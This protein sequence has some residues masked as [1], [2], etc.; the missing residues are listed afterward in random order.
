M[1]SDG[2]PILQRIHSDRIVQG[3]SCSYK[4]AT[5][6]EHGSDAKDQEGTENGL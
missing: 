1:R 5:E 4:E 2:V 6:E 3:T